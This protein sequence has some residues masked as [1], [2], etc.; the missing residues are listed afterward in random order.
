M[1]PTFYIQ[2][3]PLS[4]QCNFPANRNR[5]TSMSAVKKLKVCQLA[6]GNRRW[7]FSDSLITAMSGTSDTTQRWDAFQITI[8]LDYSLKLYLLPTYS[9]LQAQA[10]T[11]RRKEGVT[12]GNGIYKKT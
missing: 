11:R 3:F 5:Q 8:S 9:S 4:V 1:T 2:K 10:N 6:P 12:L 7:R